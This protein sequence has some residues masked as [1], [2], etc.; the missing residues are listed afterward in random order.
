[1]TVAQ[2]KAYNEGIRIATQTQ[3]ISVCDSE[4]ILDIIKG[5]DWDHARIALESF[6][7]GFNDAVAM[8]VQTQV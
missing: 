1:M 3:Q 8:D 6:V 4:Y 2:A 5:S 7:R